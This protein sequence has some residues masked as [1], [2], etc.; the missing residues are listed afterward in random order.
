MR[1]PLNCVYFQHLVGAERCSLRV[2]RYS[3]CR[4]K[5]LA[6]RKSKTALTI[7]LSSPPRPPRPRS[8]PLISLRNTKDLKTVGPRSAMQLCSLLI[9]HGFGLKINHQEEQLRLVFKALIRAKPGESLPDP[10]WYAPARQRMQKLDEFDPACVRVAAFRH[11]RCHLTPL[12]QHVATQ[13]DR[14]H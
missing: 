2:T 13:S 14:M 5:L 1:A 6:A 8:H 7:S 4:A 3:I 11:N 10:D 9:W 12:Y